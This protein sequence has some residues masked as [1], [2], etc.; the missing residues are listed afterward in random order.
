MLNDF[1]SAPDNSIV[2][3]HAC[4]HNPTGCDPS[5]DEWS[6]IANVIKQKGHVAFFDSA[7]Q[8]FASGDAERDA[9][10]LRYFVKQGLPVLLAQSFA[11]NMVSSR[12][13]QY[14]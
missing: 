10:A 2:L 11:K 14:A 5:L 12:S 9:A 6:L 8:G 3:L 13:H 1:Q 4:A 7:Y